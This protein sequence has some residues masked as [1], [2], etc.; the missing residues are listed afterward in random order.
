MLRGLAVTGLGGLVGYTGSTA[1]SD[2]DSDAK[3]TPSNETAEQMTENQNE[4]LDAWRRSAND[5]YAVRLRD[6]RFDDPPTVYLGTW[7]TN[8]FSPAAVKVLPGTTVTWKW[9]DEETAYNVV[10]TDGTFDSGKPVANK[11]STFQY[12]FEEEGNYRYVSEPHAEIGMKGLVVVESIARSEYPKVDKWLADTSNYDGS[13]LDRTTSSSVD[14]TVGA[15]GNASDLAFDP[16]AIKISPGT[17]INWIWSGKG[18][19]HSIRFKEEDFGTDAPKSDPG[20]HF[21][22][23]FTETGIYRYECGPHTALGGRGAIIVE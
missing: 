23:T 18:G 21:E 16:A 15:R 22:H 10:A 11:G 17:T 3:G 5:S 1:A 9:T 13:V 6:Y 19:M 2:S 14:V 4:S 20:K 7:G 12:T 8:S